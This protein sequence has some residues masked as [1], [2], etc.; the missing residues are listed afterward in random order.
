[1]VFQLRDSF[2]RRVHWVLRVLALVVAAA[3]GGTYPALADSSLVNNSQPITG[4][5]DVRLVFTDAEGKQQDYSLTSAPPTLLNVLTPRLQAESKLPL[6]QPGFFLGDW[7]LSANSVCQDVVGQVKQDINSSDNQAYNVSCVPMKL[8]ILH[9]QIQTQWETNPQV[10]VKGRRLVLSYYVPPFNRVPF[11]V[12]SPATCQKS[13]SNMFCASDPKYTLLYDVALQLIIT[14][15]DANSFKLPVTTTGGSGVTMQALLDGAGYEKQVDAAVSNFEKN[16]AVDAATAVADWYAALISAVVQAIKT[17]ITNAGAIV[18]DAEN[19]HLRDEVSSKLSFLASGAATQ[20]ATRAS[21]SFNLLFAALESANGLG[22]TQLDIDIGPKQSLQFRL[23]YP[24]PAKPQ[25]RN[26]IVAQNKGIHLSSPSI[27][28]GVQQVKA[29]V[30]FLVRGDNFL[31]TYTNALNIGWNHT[32]AGITKTTVQWG[33]KGGQMQESETPLDN[34]NAESLKPETAYQFRVHECDAITCAPWSE[35]LTAK[36]QAGG[37][38]DVTIWLDNNPGH[39]VGSGGLINGS[40]TTQVTIPAGTAA[41]HHTLYAAT[42]SQSR[43]GDQHPLASVD[44]AVCGPAGCGP[45]I[46][47]IDSRTQTAMKPPINLL[48]PS[49]FM[50]RGD[51]FAAGV[52]VTLHLDNA[53]G[54]KLGTAVPNKLGIFEAGFQLPFTQG[55]GHK[56]VAVQVA[57]GH[58]AQATEEVILMSQPK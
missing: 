41:G 22:F 8:G 31:D 20:A 7:S 36:T 3:L 15:Y 32:V 52:V 27:G 5:I 47:V 53:T 50:L 54:P 35:W 9:A 46:S 18:A 56:L 17:L 16:L 33:P 45:A 24:P 21:D 11:T 29:G 55:G 38:N 30:P 28:T 34:F 26:T 6:L 42:G 2:R 25:L 40:F 51:N 10:W 43:S 39:A 49:T 12:T 4:G 48:Y 13:K 58:S 44:I 1:M 19:A 57:Q 14:S 23:I 37:S